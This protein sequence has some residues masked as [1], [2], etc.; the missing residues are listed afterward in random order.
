MLEAI[1]WVRP[2]PELFNLPV[3][4]IGSSTGAAAALIA[5]VYHRRKR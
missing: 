4:L 5:A 3:G 2:E 1:A